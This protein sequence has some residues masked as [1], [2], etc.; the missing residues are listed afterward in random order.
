VETSLALFL[1]PEMVNG[2]APEEYPTFP[3]FRLVRNKRDHWPGGVWGDPSKASA[4]KGRRIM[5]VE[6]RA[7]VE[8]LKDLEDNTLS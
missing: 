6:A 3:R 4:E 7:L 5:E 2:T 1:W 8:V